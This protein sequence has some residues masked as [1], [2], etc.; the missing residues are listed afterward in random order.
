VRLASFLGWLV[1]QGRPVFDRA[2]T[3]PDSLAAVVSA[4]DEGEF[5]GED[6]LSVAWDAYEQATGDELPAGPTVQRPE[7]GPAWD[8]DDDAE[9]R[10]RYPQLTAKFFD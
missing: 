6:L 4:D 10:R 3:D 7:L 1:A 9:M 5:D 2:L 8:F